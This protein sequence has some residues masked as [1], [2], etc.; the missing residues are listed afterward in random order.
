MD[1]PMGHMHITPRSAV[2]LQ[3]CVLSDPLFT[4]CPFCSCG[5]RAAGHLH[6]HNC[7]ECTL[8][9]F[10]LLHNHFFLLAFGTC[11]LCTLSSSAAS[12]TH[13]TVTLWTLF[14]QLWLSV[15]VILAAQDQRGMASTVGV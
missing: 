8:V 1:A 15:D 4:P 9:A 6:T 7:A 2:L 13:L 5:S 3:G 10:C 11:S 14:Q 12:S